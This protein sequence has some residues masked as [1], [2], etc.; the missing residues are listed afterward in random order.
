M[1]WGKLAATFFA[2][3]IALG[4]A[5]PADALDGTIEINQAKV[6]AAGGFPYVVSATASYRLTGNLTVPA[7]TNGI[8]FFAA[9]ATLDL[10]GFSISG[11]GSTSAT[12]IGVNADGIESTVENGTVTGFGVG[13]KVGLYGIVRDMHA[14]ENGN[15]ILAGTDSIVEN[16]TANISTQ[17]TIGSGIVCVSGCRISG[18]TA[19][20][21]IAAGIACTGSVCL[22]SGNTLFNNSVGI[23]ASDATTGYGQNVLKNTTDHNG[24]TS[25]GNNLCSGTVC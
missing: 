13:V 25:L 10:N 8:N 4:L 23:S 17:T 16:C 11:P 19:N 6:L 24:G 18:N 12:P 2:A 3:A 7:A 22:I 14:D 20:S 5:G 15:G 21:N 1:K 9:N